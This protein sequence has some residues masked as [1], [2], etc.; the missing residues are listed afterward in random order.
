MTPSFSPLDD[1]DY[2]MLATRW[3]AIVSLAR[4]ECGIEIDQSLASL[5]VLQRVLDDD[6]V[7]EE[8]LLA[9]GVVLG[10]IMAKNIANLDW[11]VVEDEFGRDLCL[12]Y[13]ETT[14]QVN[15]ITMIAKRAERGE[16]VNVRQLFTAVS[17]QVDRIAKQYD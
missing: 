12:R 17:N 16:T 13:M 4:E 2:K 3:A 5:D 15:P 10:R 8:G 6:L 11:W 14:L 9:L 1:S 7:N